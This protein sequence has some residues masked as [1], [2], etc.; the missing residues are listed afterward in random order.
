MESRFTLEMNAAKNI[1]CIKKWFKQRLFRI[2]FPTKTQWT[3]FSIFA[4]SGV[5]GLQ[6]L[7]FLKYYDVLKW[8]S[9]SSRMDTTKNTNYTK[10]FLK[11]KLLKIKFPTKNS[12]WMHILISPRSIVKNVQRLATKLDRIL[13][14]IWLKLKKKFYRNIRVTQKIFENII[15]LNWKLIKIQG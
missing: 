13:M 14:E 8:K 7:P 10:K 15:V 12:Q 11:K 4:R 1:D 9:R 5:R 3:H 6:T 2:K